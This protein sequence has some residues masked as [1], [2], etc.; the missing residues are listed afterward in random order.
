M[1]AF[2]KLDSYSKKVS[3][4]PDV[5]STNLLPGQI[6]AY[7]DAAPEEIR[8]TVNKLVDDLNK[9]KLWTEDKLA[10]ESVS[11]RT[12]APDIIIRGDSSL[13]AAQARVGSDAT[14]YSTLKER[15][16]AENNSVTT[17]LAEI[18]TSVLHPPVPLNAAKGDGS[19]DDKPTIQ[20]IIDYVGSNGGGTIYFPK[21]RYY[22]SDSLV[23]SYSNVKLISFDATLDTKANHMING[24]IRVEGQTGTEYPITQDLAKGQSTLP[25]SP[26]TEYVLISTIEIYNSVR[27]YYYKGELLRTSGNKLEDVLEDDYAYLNNNLKVVEV[28]PVKNVKIDGFKFTKDFDGNASNKACGVVLNYVAN[29]EVTNCQFEN[30]DDSGLKAD[31][32]Y[33]C[34]FTNIR[35]E[36]GNVTTGLCYGISIVNASRKVYVN[37]IRGYKLRHLIAVGSS[38]FGMVRFAEIENCFDTHTY[39]NSF[40]IHEIAEY[41]HY[42]NCV[43]EYYDTGGKYN[44]FE[45]CKFLAP[46]NSGNL[47]NGGMTLRFGTKCDYTKFINCK[48]E[49]V[50]GWSNQN[51]FS[52][53]V[54]GVEIRNCTIEILDDKRIISSFLKGSYFFNFEES[55]FINNRIISNVAPVVD[56]TNKET[57]KD[58][59]ELQFGKNSVIEGN[60]FKNIN[61]PINLYASNISVKDNKFID[62]FNWVVKATIVGSLV[63]TIDNLVIESNEI[64]SPNIMFDCGTN[65]YCIQ[66]DSTTVGKQINNCR[67]ANNRIESAQINN[68]G[69][70]LNGNIRNA[71]SRNRENIVSG[72]IVKNTKSWGILVGHDYQNALLANNIVLG[73]TT[74]QITANS[75]AKTL[76]ANNITADIA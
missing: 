39:I 22:L 53:P 65:R 10:D 43:G 6:K 60:I 64:L 42:K 54:Y 69:I 30:F 7:F 73:N 63:S 8:L 18:V 59:I 34:S 14:S 25:V 55:K 71:T 40:D 12:L 15:L 24:L 21:A 32:T 33:N 13:E 44:T 17:R 36:N 26:T 66:L 35:V 56:G 51:D 41:I 38:G 67:I 57:V 61:T 58:S 49:K 3:D 75:D 9:P 31:Q 68:G 20:A 72:N 19:I 47:I 74:G 16:D 46:I 70:F 28:T 2:Q 23:I 5:P 48:F 4:L 37:N 27:S 50:V 62:C 1:M 11:L 76:Q 29:C 52:V 45:N